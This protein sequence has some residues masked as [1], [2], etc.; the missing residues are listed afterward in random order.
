V[1]KPSPATQGSDGL[2]TIEQVSAGI[3]TALA[4][5][6]VFAAGGGHQGATVF[7]RL[8]LVVVTC[9]DPR[10]D[11]A[12]VLGLE[13]GDA[14]VIRNTGGRVTPDVIAAVA[15]LG[16][17]A[18]MAML[19]GPLF[20]VAVIHHT[21]CGAAALVDDEFRER[22]AERIGADESVLRDWAVLDPAATVASD[23]ARLRSD[24][25]ISPRAAVSG[26]LYDV[27][28]GLADTV[29]AAESATSGQVS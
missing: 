13:L 22:Y 15:F 3:G 2:S 1:R 8:G 7:P 21:Q 20:E 5:N 29:V 17:I 23:V 18:E 14:V 11:P 25:A 10:V 27:V 19:E 9:M 26:H 24:G 4:R 6:A 12:H 28:T 16:Q